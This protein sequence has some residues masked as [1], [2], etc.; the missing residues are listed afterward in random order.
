MLTEIKSE[1]ELMIIMDRLV[2]S[3]AESIKSEVSKNK[4]H[5]YAVIKTSVVSKEYN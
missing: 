2:F 3:M 5:C 4:L 1:S